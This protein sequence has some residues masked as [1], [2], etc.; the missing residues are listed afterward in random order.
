MRG[1]HRLCKE[2]GSALLIAL[3][4]LMVLTIIGVATLNTSTT[5]V[6]I[7]GNY[8]TYK[9]CFYN[10]EKIIE[11]AYFRENIYTNI[12]TNIGDTQ[13]LPLAADNNTSAV[14]NENI[15]SNLITGSVT[16]MREGNCPSGESGKCRYYYIDVTARGPAN[17]ECRQ[18][19]EKRSHPIQSGS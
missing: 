10:A 9:E 1:L 16:L 5:E 11:Y 3:I 18:V 17:A 14:F 12:G 6:M 2:D 19:A 4:M 13:S 7:A 8:R 15:F